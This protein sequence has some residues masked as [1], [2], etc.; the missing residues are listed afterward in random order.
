MIESKAK[1]RDAL[2]DAEA[3]FLRADAAACQAAEVLRAAVL[4]V[5]EGNDGAAWTLLDA[6]VVVLEKYEGSA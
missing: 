2:K 3:R 5:H 6:A 4:R 1:L